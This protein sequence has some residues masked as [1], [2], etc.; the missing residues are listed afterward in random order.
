[1]RQKGKKVVI[2][3]RKS[4]KASGTGLSHYVLTGKKA[5]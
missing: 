3:V 1:M 4:C 5:K 2:A